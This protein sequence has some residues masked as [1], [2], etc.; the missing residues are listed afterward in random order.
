M[1]QSH[2]DTF[3]GHCDVAALELLQPFEDRC[4]T[5]QKNVLVK[6]MG[7][8]CSML[9]SRMRSAQKHPSFASAVRGNCSRSA[10]AFP[11]PQQ[12]MKSRSQ[13]N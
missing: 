11:K 5:N 13:E 7:G 3:P 4:F 8:F 2:V 1:F 12:T 10:L 9:L 6:R